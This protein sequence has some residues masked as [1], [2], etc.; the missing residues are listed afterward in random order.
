MKFQ[1]FKFRDM[2]ILG[3]HGVVV[4]KVRS[5]LTILGILFGVWSVIAML[6]INA[7]LGVQSQKDLRRLGSTNIIVDSVKPETDAANSGSHHGALVYGLSQSD[8]E[9]LAAN[10]PGVLQEA[11]L[12]KTQKTASAGSQTRA[13]T[14]LGVEPNYLAVANGQPPR[15]RFLVDADLLLRRNVCVIPQSFADRMFPAEDALGQILHL[16][17]ADGKPFRIVGIVPFLPAAL[18]GQLGESGDAVFI[19]LTTSRSEFGTMSIQYMQGSRSVE[20]VEIS[21]C[22]LRMQDE[23]AVLRGAPVVRNLLARDHPRGDYA[24]KIPVEEIELMK[25]DTRRWNVMFFLIASVSLL[26]GGIGIMNIMLASVTERTREI[27]VRRALG[28]KK[29]DIVT[30]FLVEA[31]TLTT[32]GGLLGIAIGL[33][34]PWLL[35]QMLTIETLITPM[36]LI[37]P[38]VMAVVV[39]LLSGL[40]PALRAAKLDPIE[41]LRHE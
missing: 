37:V 12:H 5:V 29:S 35:Q 36:T 6:A 17:D 14:V 19:P 23:S 13:V 4:H 16:I 33:F 15:G 31:V 26:V 2:V 7:G 30:Q 34:V 27:G 11:I 8:V 32:L 9:R 40:Y 3:L 1:F 18:S 28:A 41:A 20:K 24:L 22:I 38:F 21:Q 39:G 10:T 25:A